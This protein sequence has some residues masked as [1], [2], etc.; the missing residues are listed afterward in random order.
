MDEDSPDFEA[1]FSSSF[2]ALS[3]NYEREIPFSEFGVWSWSVKSKSEVCSLKLELKFEVEV[4]CWSL[5]LKF[6]VWS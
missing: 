5:K 4:R 1:S 2:E 3:Q 6:E